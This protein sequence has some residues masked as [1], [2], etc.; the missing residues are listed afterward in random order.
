MTAVA[1]A[2]RRAVADEHDAELFAFVLLAPGGL[3]KTSSGKI[4]RRACRAAFLDGTLDALGEWRATGQPA[5]VGLSRA[6][7]LAAPP[8]ER[9]A[10]LE[11]HFRDQV[12]RVLRL[13]PSA[14]DPHQ[15][16]QALGLSSLSIF[17]LKNALEESLG[18][19]ISV[20]SFMQ[21][22]SIAQ[23]ALAVLAELTAAPAGP[24]SMNQALQQVQQLSDEQVKALLGPDSL[25]TRGAL[26]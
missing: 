6:A 19:T 7:I 5:A 23:L 12:A 8:P 22:A 3:P 21:G 15:P 26:Q 20:S 4:Q 18:V 11:N 9:R 25:V 2:V 24:P 16:L 17:E 14:V 1:A 13:A 10:L